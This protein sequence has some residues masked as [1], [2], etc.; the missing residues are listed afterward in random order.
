MLQ[1]HRRGRPVDPAKRAALLAAARHLFLAKGFDAV[2]MG[3][4]AAHAHVSKA[5]LYANFS[6]RGALLEAVIRKE[7]ERIVGDEYA[8]EGQET[9]LQAMLT[10]FGLRMLTFLTDPERMKFEW[11]IAAAAERYPD[12]TVRFFDA[13]PGRA[14]AML[15]KLI[16][17]AVAQGIV[18][19]ED[20]RE[21]AGDLVGLWQG[22][23]RIETTLRYRKTPAIRELR[24]RAA[25]G[26]QLFL[27]LYGQSKIQTYWAS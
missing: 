18:V 17:S 4:I 26:V 22:F 20:P 21:A 9:N 5:T 14:R 7:S 8:T 23:I 19:V 16:A 10:R 25:R 12:L 11:L 1:L 2:T 3:E 6:N 24:R 13:G 15:A 27:R